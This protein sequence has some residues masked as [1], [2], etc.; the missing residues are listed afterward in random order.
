MRISSV[1]A[2]RVKCQFL[3]RCYWCIPFSVLL[4][5]YATNALHPVP[6]RSKC[7]RM[8]NM[9]GWMD[10]IESAWRTGLALCGGV[11]FC[12]DWLLAC[13]AGWLATSCLAAF[14]RGSRW[15]CASVVGWLLAIQRLMPPC[16]M[17]KVC[18]NENVSFGVQCLFGILLY[19]ECRRSC[20]PSSLWNTM[21]ALSVCSYLRN[22][23]LPGIFGVDD[24]N[25]SLSN[26]MCAQSY[27]IVFHW[28]D[29]VADRCSHR[30]AVHSVATAY[31]I[32]FN[33]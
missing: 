3:L 33:R 6:P 7:T 8:Q 24:S 23:S 26:W 2:F 29:M 20:R 25:F 19:V 22:H 10:G 14:S 27:L 16:K 32:M 9:D 28:R 11:W 15:L 17:C 21:V 13:L 1:F 30:H 12:A 5:Y 31:E 4:H 18:A